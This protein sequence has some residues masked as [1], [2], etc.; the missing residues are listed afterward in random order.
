MFIN[1]LFV[2]QGYEKGNVQRGVLRMTRKRRARRMQ[3]IMAGVL[4]GKTKQNKETLG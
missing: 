1:S 3:G 2:G 4:R